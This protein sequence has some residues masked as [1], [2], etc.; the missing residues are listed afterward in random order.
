M[1]GK[2]NPK[3]LSEKILR[4][5]NSLTMKPIGIELED[6]QWEARTKLPDQRHD[7]TVHH[8]QMNKQDSIRNRNKLILV[9]GKATAVCMLELLQGIWSH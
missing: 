1:T 4:S 9:C 7:S 8:K 6:L 5:S 3:K 2:E